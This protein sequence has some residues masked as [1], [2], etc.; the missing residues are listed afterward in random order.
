MSTSDIKETE[1][2]SFV[3]IERESNELSSERLSKEFFIKSS[4]LILIAMV[5]SK[6]RLTSSLSSPMPSRLRR[7]TLGLVKLE[8]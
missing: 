6:K 8:H 1:D 3:E 4:N 7:E 2:P 5:A